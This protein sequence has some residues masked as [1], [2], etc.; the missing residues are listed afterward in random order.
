MPAVD[1]PAPTRQRSPESK[2]PTNREH[3]PDIPA[4][5]EAP[6]LVLARYPA[7]GHRGPAPR[8]A[9]LPAPPARSR[10]P[11]P[12]WRLTSTICPYSSTITIPSRAASTSADATTSST[13]PSPVPGWLGSPTT[14]SAITGPP[15]N[16]TDDRSPDREPPRRRRPIGSSSRLGT[17][18][19]TCGRAVASRKLARV[20]GQRPDDTDCE[21]SM[22]PSSHLHNLGNRPVTPSLHVAPGSAAVTTLRAETSTTALRAPR[23]SPMPATTLSTPCRSSSPRSP[24]ARR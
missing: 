19:A 11:P 18:P 14:R 8:P 7:A 20:Q 9:D 17:G 23:C 16:P 5:Q 3:P 12:T 10:T 1:N 15:D 6:N 22:H 13:D 4:S 24:P 2:V 21:H